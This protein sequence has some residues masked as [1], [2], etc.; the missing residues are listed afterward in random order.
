MINPGVFWSLTSA[1]LWSTTF[2]CARFLMRDRMID[3]VSLSLIRFAA[4]GGILFLYGYVFQR[5]R[6][7]AVTRRDV[8]ALAILSLFGV[9]GMSALLF[10][11]QQST[12]AIN[13]S[14][15][16][17]LN[18]V[19]IFFI[20]LGLGERASVRQFG[21]IV[22]SLLGCCLV[23]NIL[24]PTGVA[25][26]F[27]H[28]S[29]D[30]LVFASA[31]CWAIYSVFGR[32]TVQRLGGFAVTAWTMLFGAI[33]LLAIFMFLPGER[34]MPA[35]PAA[36]SVVAYIAVFPTAVAFFAWFEAMSKINLAL[37]NVMQYLTPVFTI[38]L[39]WMLLGERISPLNMIGIGI[40]LAGV[41][42]IGADRDRAPEAPARPR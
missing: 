15:I 26:D 37:L 34:T 31:C 11:G 29:G 8:P 41:I 33:E 40:V 9:T 5:N 2:V 36:W 28:L 30:L 42:L 1:F 16:M 13:T 32:K 23:S 39:A 10:L 17:Q 3:P 24:T 6:L 21:G 19:V 22:L 18:P 12:T 27:N 38:L 4:A 25:Y 14:I 20:G 35:T 7:L